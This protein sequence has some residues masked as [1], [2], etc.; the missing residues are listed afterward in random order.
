MVF[1]WTKRKF[2]IGNNV[3]T[4]YGKGTGYGTVMNLKEDK[5]LVWIFDVHRNGQIYVFKRTKSG[6][7]G[8]KAVWRQQDK[9][10]ETEGFLYG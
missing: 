8:H 6:K 3:K 1:D 9:V 7:P 5:V 10:T 2:K 4:P